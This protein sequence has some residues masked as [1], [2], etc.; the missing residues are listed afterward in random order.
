MTVAKRCRAILK[1]Q[2][3]LLALSLTI[4]VSRVIPDMH[5]VS[6]VVAGSLMGAGFAIQVGSSSGCVSQNRT[7]KSGCATQISPRTV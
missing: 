5:F 2:A 7:A 6:D 1:L 3:T 4:A